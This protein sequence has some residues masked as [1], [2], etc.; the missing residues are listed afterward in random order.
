MDLA[1]ILNDSYDR[2]GRSRCLVPE[3]IN[4]QNTAHDD[5]NQKALFHGEVFHDLSAKQ[6]SN[7]KYNGDSCFE[8]DQSASNIPRAFRPSHRENT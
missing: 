4:N 7:D 3:E 8:N 5:K 1:E 2:A 6:K